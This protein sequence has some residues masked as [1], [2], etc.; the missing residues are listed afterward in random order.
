MT[1]ERG[2]GA[3]AKCRGELAQVPQFGHGMRGCRG[4][5]RCGV[6]GGTPGVGEQDGVDPPAASGDRGVDEFE[7]VGEMA[8]LT[9]FDCPLQA[10]AVAEGPCGVTG[11]GPG[12]QAIQR[13]VSRHGGGR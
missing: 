4:A 10:V 6:V 2:L 1:F 9:G 7:Q 8:H 12:Q 11:G 13:G 3:A 5:G